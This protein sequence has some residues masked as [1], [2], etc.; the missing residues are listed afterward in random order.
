ME[1]PL[2]ASAGEGKG[3][4]KA[5]WGGGGDWPKGGGG[6]GKGGGEGAVMAPCWAHEGGHRRRRAGHMREGIV[7][8]GEL[9]FIPVSG[10]RAPTLSG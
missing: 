5:Q 4:G 3:G 9:I 2:P 10:A 6:G 8:A 1:A 7:G